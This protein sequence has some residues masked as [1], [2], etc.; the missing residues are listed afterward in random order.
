[1]TARM[2]SAPATPQKS[3]RRCRSGGMPVCEKIS[4]KMNRLSTESDFS[5][6]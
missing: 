6:A 1:M 5:S 4:P 2:T 3:A